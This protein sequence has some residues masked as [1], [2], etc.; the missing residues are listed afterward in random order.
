M[1]RQLGEID[2]LAGDYDL[3]HRRVAADGTSTSGCGLAR[4]REIFVVKL[5]LA[6]LEGG[7]EA[8][9][10]AGGLGDELDLLGSRLSEQHAPCRC[11]R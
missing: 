8:L 7:G 11:L 6:G 5:V 9:A 2:V 3:M 10:V 1:E 4:R